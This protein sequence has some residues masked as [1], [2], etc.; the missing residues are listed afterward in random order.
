MY[1]QIKTELLLSNA[2][3]YLSKAQLAAYLKDIRRN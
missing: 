3:L 2:E 1:Q